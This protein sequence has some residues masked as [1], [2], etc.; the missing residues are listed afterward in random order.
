[1]KIPKEYRE[2]ARAAH[3][4]HWTIEPTRSGH[5][6]WR[7]PRGNVVF[8]PGTPSTNGTGILRIKSKLRKAGLILGGTDH[9]HD[10]PTGV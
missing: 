9:T 5:L 2:L 10:Y 6:A 3:G 4:Q 1:M 8:T 7:P